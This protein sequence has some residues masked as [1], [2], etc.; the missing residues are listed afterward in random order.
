MAREGA[1]DDEPVLRAGERDVEQAAMLAQVARF[2]D[3]AEFAAELRVVALLAGPEGRAVFGDEQAVAI[4]AM[5]SAGVG[6]DDDGRFEALGAVHGHHADFALRAGEFAL[7]LAAA[8]FDGVE[9]ELQAGRLVGVE[10]GGAIDE[11]GDGFARGTAEAGED[12]L[13]AGAREALAAFE[14]VG[15][16]FVGR[17]VAAREHVGEEGAD[18]REVR[19]GCGLQRGP[20]MALAADWR[21]RRDASS[22]SH[23][24]SSPDM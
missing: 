17:R 7:H 23:F 9:E 20:E 4:A 12:Q 22:S 5:G 16:E 2:L 6:Q 14:R 19:L 1:A 21:G 10:G 11:G 13:P 8:A 24:S 15:E 3:G 18:G